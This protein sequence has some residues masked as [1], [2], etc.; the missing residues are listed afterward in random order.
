MRVGLREPLDKLR[1]LH[2]GHSSAR[3][4]WGSATVPKR[5]ASV[6][7]AADRKCVLLLVWGLRACA[8]DFCIKSLGANCPRHTLQLMTPTSHEGIPQDLPGTAPAGGGRQDQDASSAG[9]GSVQRCG[10]WII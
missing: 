3:F 10:L 1:F 8:S 4:C 7:Q 9:Y 2:R 5:R 6:K